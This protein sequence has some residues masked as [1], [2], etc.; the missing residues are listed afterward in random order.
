[1]KELEVVRLMEHHMHKDVIEVVKKIIFMLMKGVDTREQLTMMVC[2][3]GKY[4]T[5]DNTCHRKP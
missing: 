5:F 1:M 3:K 2:Y 4:S